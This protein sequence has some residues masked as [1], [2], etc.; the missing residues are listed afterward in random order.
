MTTT[1]VQ[2]ATLERYRQMFHDELY[3]SVMPF[4]L[5]H[6]LD[7]EHGGYFNCLDR[8]G[9]VYDTRKHVWMQGREV[10]MTARIH[11]HKMA[12]GDAKGAAPFLDAASVGAPFLRKFAP[13]GDRQVHFALTRDGKPAGIQ[14]KFYAEVFY[15]MALNEY[16]RATN[17]DGMRAEA[18]SVFAKILELANDPS[19]LGRPALAGA[20]ATSEL[21]HPMVIL[22]LVDELSDPGTAPYAD[23]AKTWIERLRRHVRPELRMAL[24]T[25][26]ADGS[27]LD[28]PEGRVVNPGHAIEAGWFLLT[29]ARRT[30]DRSLVPMALQLMEWSFDYGWDPEDGGIFY[31]LDRE[32]YSPLQLEWSM[33]LWWPHC[34]TLVA[35]LM[36]YAE[37]GD[38]KWFALFEKVADWTW[39]HFPDPRFGEWYGYL[40]RHGRVNQRF[41]GGPYKGCFHVPR[42]L[43]LCLNLFDEILARQKA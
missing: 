24:E 41:K 8:D 40:D 26:D 7:R 4:W 39:A 1:S 35:F 2:R 11:N 9:R 6:S 30:G 22:S 10:W 16:G 29:I 43:F 33:K 3:G 20:P 12:A 17:D 18:R 13:R 42:A 36:A 28:S 21:A 23:V 15:V 19:P 14:R 32:G 27:L 25:I 38:P 34:E 31:F 5:K 37:T